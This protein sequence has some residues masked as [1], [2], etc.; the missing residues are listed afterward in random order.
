MQT[1]A[2]CLETCFRNFLEALENVQRKKDK[3]EGGSD[4][5]CDIQHHPSRSLLP[6]RFHAQVEVKC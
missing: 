2:N 3:G 6:F 1:L 4:E 5:A